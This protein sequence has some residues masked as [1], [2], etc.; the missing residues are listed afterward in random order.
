MVIKE[1]INFIIKMVI[2]IDEAIKI[3]ISMASIIIIILIIN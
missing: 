1:S 2:T 3:M